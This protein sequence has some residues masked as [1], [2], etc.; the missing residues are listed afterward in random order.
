MG[1]I[2]V[3]CLKIQGSCYIEGRFRLTDSG[4]CGIE[5]VSIKL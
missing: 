5:A 1:I 3:F 2:I 4:E